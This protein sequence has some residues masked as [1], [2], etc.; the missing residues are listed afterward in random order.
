MAVDVEG[1]IFT[2]LFRKGRHTKPHPHLLEGLG[3]EEMIACPEF[4]LIDEMIQV[5]DQEAFLA[6]R[7][8]ARQEAV[9]A[10]GSSGAALC[11]VR[12]LL[13]EAGN[14]GRIVT[15]FPDS[16]WRYLRTIY[17]D[18]WMRKNGFLAR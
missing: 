8:L 9:F 17:Q 16:G 11:G 2:E 18:D 12:K 6:T 13:E 15:I 10:G 1:S 5:S 4:D 7:E 3:D 14:P